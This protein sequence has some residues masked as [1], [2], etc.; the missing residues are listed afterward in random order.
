MAIRGVITF[1][2]FFGISGAMAQPT[3]SQE[4]TS[5]TGFDGN[6]SG[7]WLVPV[8][9]LNYA[10][11]R[12]VRFGGE[13]RTRIEGEDGIRYTTTNDAYLLSRFRFNLTIHPAKWLT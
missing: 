8:Q 5:Q 4:P 12:W 1:I 2:S 10:L 7:G 13:Y 11:P 9:T 3:E 6:K